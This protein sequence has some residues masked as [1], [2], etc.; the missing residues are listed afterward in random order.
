[1]LSGIHVVYEVTILPS[2]LKI[3]LSFV[4]PRTTSLN[5]PDHGKSLHLVWLPAVITLA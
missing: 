2:F 4:H 1:M 3:A 5:F